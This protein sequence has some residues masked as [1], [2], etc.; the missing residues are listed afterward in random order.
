MEWPPNFRNL[1]IDLY[2]RFSKAT[3]SRRGRIL[4]AVVGVV[5]LLIALVP[6]LIPADSFRPSLEDQLSTALG[7]KVSLGH[8][9]FS[10]FSGT[11]VAR[12]VAI[13]DDPAFG[14]SPFIEAKSLHIGVRI[15]PF[16][17]HRE[18]RITKLTIDSPSIHLIHGHGSRWNYS[19]FGAAANAQKPQQ[20]STLP[21]LTVGA[22]KIE[23]G[24][25]AVSSLPATGKQLT[26]TGIDL[27]VQ[28]LSFLKSFPFQLSARLP[29]AGSVDLRGTAGPLDQKNAADTPFKA[30]LQVKHFDPVAAGLVQPNQGISM[31][32]DIDAQLASDGTALTSNGKIQAA[33]LQLARTGSP[34]PQPVNL[35]YSISENLESR[36][37]QVSDIS[38]HA[39]AAAAHINGTFSMTGQTIDLNLKLAAPSL[40]VDQLEQLLPAFGV[41]LPSGSSLHGGTLTANLAVTGPAEATTVAGPVEIDN[42]QLAG[43]SLASKIQGINP[44]GGSGG[45]TTIQTLRAEINSSPQ[46]TRIT[47][48]YGNVPQIGTASGGG[49]VSP[50]GALDFQLVAK[51]NSSTGIGAV[52]GQAVNAVGGVVGGFLHSAAKSTPLANGIPLTITGTTASPSIHANLRALLK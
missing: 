50:N 23:N 48:I 37:G 20:P 42:S 3:H 38:I 12:D 30:S 32:V 16:L 13:A 51:F 45:G 1:R 26:Y 40:P 11:V 33:H 52:A 7:R 14:A 15:V 6:F 21:D 22:L 44:L 19:S 31:M 46:T 36:T 28:H 43:F 35:D 34:A 39:G 41:S 9:S 10:L 17:F 27:A 2:N 5:I 24:T 4:L 47:N 49:T 25:A 18:V 8:L 29:A